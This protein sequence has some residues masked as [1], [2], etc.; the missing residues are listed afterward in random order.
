MT[1]WRDAGLP[2]VSLDFITLRSALRDA[3]ETGLL[4]P[5]LRKQTH[6]H[7]RALIGWFGCYDAAAATINARWGGGASKGTISKKVSEQLDWTVADIV[8]LEDAVGQYP[9][10]RALARRLSE[11]P[12]TK[13]RCLVVQSGTIARECGEAISAIL[14]AGQSLDASDMA[15]AIREIDESIESLRLARAL[16]NAGPEGRR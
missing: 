16:L 13:G 2:P 4:M 15:E 11:R 1:V 14:A 5:D 12:S 9:V 7:L 8:A 6:A 3:K 10:T